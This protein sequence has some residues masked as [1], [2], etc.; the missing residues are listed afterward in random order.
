MDRRSSGRFSLNGSQ[1]NNLPVAES[2][3]IQSSFLSSP[4]QSL[5]NCSYTSNSPSTNRGRIQKT[6]MSPASKIDPRK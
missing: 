2:T 1:F 3:Q 6:I 5:G 4:R